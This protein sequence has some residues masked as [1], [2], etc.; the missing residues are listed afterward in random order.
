MRVSVDG[1]E[2]FVGTGSR[3][4]ATDGRPVVVFLHGAGM[5]HTIWVMPARYFARHGFAVLAPDLP[6]HG[7]SGG[8]PL[9]SIEDMS[10][11]LAAL[12]AALGVSRAAVVGHSLGSLLAYAFAAR[13]PE[14]VTSLVLLGASLP[15]PVTEA[16][17]EAAADDDHAAFDMANVWSHSTQGSLGG[18]PVPGMF[19][20]EGGLRLMERCRPGVFHA[21]LAACN[22]FVPAVTAAIQAPV[23][24]VAGTADRMTPEKAGRAVAA[25]LGERAIIRSLPGSGHSM[26][27]EQPNQVLDILIEALVPRG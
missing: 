18:N 16:L 12:L 17:L 15:M 10:A 2:V 11:W 4:F 5:D 22:A 6:G 1:H 23:T 13:Q 9:K 3:P 7:L 26:L 8:P 21:D 25:S 14:M 19:V 24:V 27:S 20:L